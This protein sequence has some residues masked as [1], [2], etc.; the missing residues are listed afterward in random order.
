MEISM[1]MRL[2]DAGKALFLAAFFYRSVFMIQAQEVWFFTEGTNE[3]FYDQ[4]I[5]DVANLGESAFEHT[6]PPG[7]PQYNDKVPCSTSS[8]KG[9]TALRFTYTS[10]PAGNWKVSIFRNDWSS[11][12]ISGMDSLSFWA[13]SDSGIPSSA[14]PE[15]GLRALKKAVSGEMTSVLYP[16]SAH[17][18]GI[19]AQQWTRI[20]FPLPVIM[21]DDNNSQLDFGAVKGIIFNQSETNNTSRTI[22]IDEITAFRSLNS[23]PP[24]TGLTATGFDSH[25]ELQWTT[26]MEDLSYRIYA[27]FNG[28]VSY[29]L[30]AE[31]TE[32]NYQDFVPAEGKNSTVFYRVVTLAQGKESQPSETTATL[33]DFSDDELL[34]MVQRYTFRFFWEGAHQ[35]TG[36][37]LERTDGGGNT[38]ASGGTGMGLMAMIAAHERGYRD[39]DEIKDR[40]LMILSFLETCD[41]HHGA[42]SH[43]YDASTG[44][45]QPFSTDDDGGDLVETSYVAQGL[46]A[47]KNYFTGSDSRSL[48]IREKADLLWQGIEWD[49]YR[50]NDQDVLYWHWSPRV[51][52]KINMKVRGWNEC[53]ITYVMAASSPTYTIP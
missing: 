16:L 53:L 19:P 30:R 15:I 24:V 14:L 38:V 42:W 25:A 20:V 7:L 29:E 48:Q 47:L 37:A 8:Y 26:P 9:S 23:I 11:A 46:I 22:L 45:T 31:T 32:N 18:A 27:S 39:Q 2:P 51:G 52:F 44:N 21:D 36:M 35:A 28:G 49:W 17:N 4:G 41:R 3:N 13:Y 40:I 43:W 1:R 10:A 12:D 50:Q 34:D 33:R 6:Y 5:V